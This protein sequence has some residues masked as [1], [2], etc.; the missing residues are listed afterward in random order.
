MFFKPFELPKKPQI[1]ELR[2]KISEFG[3]EKKNKENI[4]P[5]IEKAMERLTELGGGHIIVEKGD[6]FCDGPIHFKSNIDLNIE[7]GAVITFT[8]EPEKYLPV[9]FTRIEGLRCYN[10]SPL[11]YGTDLENIS[12]TGSG[13][14]NGN[15]Y[16]WWKWNRGVGSYSS[17]C[18]SVTAK[19][20]EMAQNLVPVEKRVAGTRRDGIRPYF[21]QFVNCR[22]ILIEGVRFEQSPFWTVAPVFSENI[23]IRGVHWYSDGESHN[24][25]SID[26]DSCKNC[27]VEDCVVESSSDDCV[28]VKSGRDKDGIDANVPT[29]NVLV[30]N[31]VFKNAGGCCVVGS[32][33]SGGIRNVRFENC[34]A[35]N[36]GTLISVK[37]APNRGNII[38]N[39]EFEN[40]HIDKAVA[41]VGISKKYWIE[42]DGEG[43]L[44]DMPELK[45]IYVKDVSIGKCWHGIKILGYKGY[46]VENII[47]D[48]VSVSC[49]ETCEFIEYAENLSMKDVN[50][51]KTDEYYPWE[52]VGGIKK[53]E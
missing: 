9:V 12:I 52:S 23:I 13:T 50:I 19:L 5:A 16:S 24:T 3:D 14:L 4:K 21:L 31:C 7:E 43:E 17:G 29:E 53:S 34:E 28:C 41:S 36:C 33:T 47:L 15:G 22:N 39:I 46:P 35:E 25:D 2:V 11:I 1:P 44:V 20:Y 37:T 30:R 38:E 10:Y 48:N 40:I 42:Y 27:L 18:G 8:D 26:L 32:E 49:Y 51:R 6:Y 45:N